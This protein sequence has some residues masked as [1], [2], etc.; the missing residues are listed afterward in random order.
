MAKAKKIENSNLVAIRCPGCDE[1]HTL[2][3]EAGDGRP[4]WGFNG[5]FE[6]PT[7]TP[8]LLVRRGHFVPGHDNGKCWCHYKEQH[9]E[10]APFSCGVCHS[11]I[12]N[13]EIQ[14]LTDCTH[15]LAGKTVPLED[16]DAAE[17]P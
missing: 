16:I 14:F 13:G 2:N 3:I 15:K 4:C 12:R 9:G 17:A 10:D 1:F 7:F 5:D 11:F 6:K 8:S